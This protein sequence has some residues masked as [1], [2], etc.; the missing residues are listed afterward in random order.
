MNMGEN[1]K[2]SIDFER[3]GGPLYAGRDRGELARQKYQLDDADK[4]RAEVEVSVPEQTYTVTSSF[5]LGLFGDSVRAAGSS[6]EF[7]RR[8]HFRMPDR[9][10]VKFRD[11]ADRALREKKPLI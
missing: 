4:D 2:L 7:F 8:F 10:V 11:F 9:M 5:F 3:L 6:E 1:A